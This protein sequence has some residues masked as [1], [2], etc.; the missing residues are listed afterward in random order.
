MRFNYRLEE[1]AA[2]SSNAIRLLKL[3]GFDESITAAAMNRAEQMGMQI[4]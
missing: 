3:M 1:G 4:D 2:S